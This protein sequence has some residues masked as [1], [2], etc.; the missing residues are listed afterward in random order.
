MYDAKL[1]GKCALVTGSTSGLGLIIAKQMMAGGCHVVLNGFGD[2]DTIE[3]QR[4]LLE[5]TYKVRVHYVPANIS[6]EAGAKLLV[7]SVLEQLGSVDILVHNTSERQ[8]S[9]IGQLTAKQWQQQIAVNLSSAFY[10]V[11]RA[12]P[13]MHKHSWGRIIN[14]IPAQNL[15]A[16]P[17][18]VGLVAAKYGLI[19]LTKVVAEEI[20]LAQSGDGNITCNAMCPGLLRDSLFSVKKQ[21]ALSE[22]IKEPGG[23]AE[24]EALTDLSFEQSMPSSEQL[25]QLILFLCSDAASAINGE[26][27]PVGANP[28]TRKKRAV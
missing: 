18:K 25:G 3:T 12:L 2:P 6:S 4:K 24:N 15:A 17:D 5:Q 8:L 21:P 20:N 11:K 23:V 27:L 28:V 1:K 26:I 7:D 19:G 22:V 16:C 14:L 10:L 9:A 13:S